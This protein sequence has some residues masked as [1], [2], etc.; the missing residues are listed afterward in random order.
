MRRW[1]RRVAIAFVTLAALAAVPLLYVETACTEPIETATIRQALVAP[2]QRRPESRTYLTYPEWYIVHAY[3]DFARVLEKGDEHAFAFWR[4]I[5]GFWTSLCLLNRRASRSGGADFDVK[6]M[7]YTIGYSFSAELALKAL[8]EE[9]IGR[10]A[11]TLRGSDATPQD[12]LAARMAADYAEFLQQTPWYRY[13]FGSWRRE[14]WSLP[15]DGSRLRSWERSLALGSEWSAKSAYAALIEKAVGA[16]EPAAGENHLVVSG[17]SQHDLEAIE[18]LNIV[19]SLGDERFVV[20][21]PRYRVFTRVLQAIADRGGSLQEIAGNDD[22]LVS[23][24][25][26]RGGPL[27]P[28]GKIIAAFPRQAADDERLL[29]DTRVRDLTLL[30]RESSQGNFVLEHVYDY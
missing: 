24:L 29:V 16:L 9:T 20:A 23:I 27:P 30:M 12:R 28:R 11:V 6:A 17:L 13:D 25:R 22:I 26:P 7:L 15:R 5:E 8:Y 14:L 18:G 2:S 3:E 19:T 1:L 4:S 10:V 21:G